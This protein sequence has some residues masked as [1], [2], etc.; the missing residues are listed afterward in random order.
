MMNTVISANSL[1][2]G[3]NKSHNR[4]ERP[5]GF[6]KFVDKPIPAVVMYDEYAEKHN[7]SNAWK[8]TAGI[9]VVAA[10]LL[11]RAYVKG[12]KIIQKLDELF[13][14]A[15]KNASHSENVE[16][17]KHNLG[18]VNEPDLFKK[19]ARGIGGFFSNNKKRA[20]YLLKNAMEGVEL[21]KLA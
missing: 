13:T 21:N 3:S 12:G 14:D 11:T 5:A 10:A 2:F 1:R 15:V 16:R 19:I 17:L 8:W 7:R 6:S 9:V 18:L 20:E 4:Q